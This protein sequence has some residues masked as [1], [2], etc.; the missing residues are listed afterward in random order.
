[1]EN[2]RK[3]L[4]INLLNEQI[5]ELLILPVKPVAK[6]KLV[7]IV[8]AVLVTGQLPLLS[9]QQALNDDNVPDWG[10]HAATTLP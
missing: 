5:T 7:G 6:S 2:S 8:V 4:V 9:H 3:R 10:Q 1:L